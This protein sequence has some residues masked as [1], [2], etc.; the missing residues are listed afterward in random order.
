MPF[1]GLILLGRAFAAFFA[2][3]VLLFAFRFHLGLS[4]VECSQQL[5][6]GAGESALVF[7]GGGHF[8]KGLFGILTNRIAPQIKHAMRGFRRGLAGQAFTRNQ[9]ERRRQRHLVLTRHAIIAFGFAFFDQ[10]GAQIGRNASHVLG[11]HGFHTHLFQR[12]EH[13]LGFAPRW[14][15]A[16]M[17]R[18]I[19]MTKLERSGIRRTTELRHFIGR[20]SAGWQR[21]AHALARNS[22]RPGLESHLH[23]RIGMRHGA[24]HARGG[25]LEFFLPR[26]ILLAAHVLLSGMQWRRQ[27]LTPPLLDSAHLAEQGA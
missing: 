12:V 23:F 6:R 7:G 3:F 2:F 21:Q 20:Q 25:A 17:Q 15:A 19:M 24:Q 26:Q 14:D 22:G 13:F 5:A 18:F 9:A 10:L 8:G 11:P 16:G 27:G 1:A 4:E